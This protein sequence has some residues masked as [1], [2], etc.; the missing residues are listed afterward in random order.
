MSKI[1]I[2]SEYNSLVTS[3]LISKVNNELW[4]KLKT[5]FDKILVV[6]GTR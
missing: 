6:N 1:V 4:L 2:E 3:E 5:T